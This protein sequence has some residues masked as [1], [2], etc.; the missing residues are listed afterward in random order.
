MGWF[1]DIF[2]LMGEWILLL[3]LSALVGLAIGWYV[4]QHRPS[5]Q[6]LPE[7]PVEPAED[8]RHLRLVQ[9]EQQ[10]APG[11]HND[12]E[13]LTAELASTAAQLA[14]TT[15]ELTKVTAERDQFK[16]QRDRLWEQLSSIDSLV[17]DAEVD[18]NSPSNPTQSEIIGDK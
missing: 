9:S 7:A 6:S 2:W 18:R 14:S 5:S 4:W 8:E 3:A 1:P 15:E 11:P 12:P 10:E 13:P 16:L 17:G